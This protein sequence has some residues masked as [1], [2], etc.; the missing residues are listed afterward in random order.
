MHEN[1]ASNIIFVCGYMPKISA[2]SSSL[3]ALKFSVYNFY[4]TRVLLKILEA[5][6]PYKLSYFEPPRLCLLAKMAAETVRRPV[7]ITPPP[8]PPPLLTCRSVSSSEQL[9]DIEHAIQAELV[10]TLNKT[11]IFNTM[12]KTVLIHAQRFIDKKYQC[13]YC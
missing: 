6:F 13:K 8:P 2:F 3:V 10:K 9:V 5:E 1:S 12:L 4:E 11:D 7:T